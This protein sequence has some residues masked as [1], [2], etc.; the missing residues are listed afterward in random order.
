MKKRCR[1]TIYV[2]KDTRAAVHVDSQNEGPSMW[3]ADGPALG[4]EQVQ[5]NTT[6]SR[7]PNEV[8]RTGMWHEVDGRSP[9]LNMPFVRERFSIA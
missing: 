3:Y 7:V 2:T 5:F 1:T 9:H 6:S 4:G 8:L